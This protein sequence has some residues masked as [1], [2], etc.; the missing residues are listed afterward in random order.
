MT[1]CYLLYLSHVV[2][3]FFPSRKT[4][5]SSLKDFYTQESMQKYEKISL[6]VPSNLE[7]FIGSCS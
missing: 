2:T 6:S 1:H 4:I 3:K 7:N 5:L